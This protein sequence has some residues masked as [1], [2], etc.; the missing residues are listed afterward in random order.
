MT[1]NPSPV[2]GVSVPPSFDGR[3]F[4]SKQSLVIP[5]H[6]EYNLDDLL[7]AGVKVSPVDTAILH[8][9][10]AV[11]NNV[12]ALTESSAVMNDDVQPE[13]V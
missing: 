2:Y 3:N 5:T 4:F 1:F 12:A 9:N 7:S 10:A 6:D 11:S 13:N 8:D